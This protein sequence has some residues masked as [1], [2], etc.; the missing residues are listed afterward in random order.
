M[1]IHQINEP[2]HKK[3]HNLINFFFGLGL[4]EG[5][6][7]AGYLILLP[8]DSTSSQF[9]NLSPARLA[10][11][12]A[13]LFLLIIN[14]GAGY[15]Y[16]KNDNFR[17]KLGS[18]LTGE[19][20]GAI[21]LIS[22]AI[23]SLSIAAINI[24]LEVFRSTEVYLYYAY[25]QRLSPLLLY[26]AVWALQLG[27]I[28]CYINR[29][30]LIDCFKAESAFIKSW[31]FVFCGLILIVVLISVTRIGLNADIIG[32]GKP[33]VPLLEW[34]IWLGILLVLLARIFANGRL[35]SSFTKFQAS[36]KVLSNFLLS[37]FIWGGAVI[38]WAGQP[39]PPGFF[40]TAPRPPNFEIYPFSD[41]AFYD[42]HAQSM[43]IGMGFRGDSIPPRPLY[44]L[45]LT[46]YHLI[47]GQDYSKVILVQTFILALFPMIVFWIGKK[48]ANQT[49]GF[50]TSLF[51]I[52]REWT[53]ILATPFTSDISNSKLLFADLPAALAISLLLLIVI[54]WLEKP[55][56]RLYALQAGGILGICLLI[57]T[58][59]IILLPIIL[60]FYW[61]SARKLKFK[62]LFL[63]TILFMIGFIL[64]I[65]PWLFRNYQ[66]TGQLVFDHPESQTRVMAQRYST[67]SDLSDLEARPDETTGQYNQRLTDY[68]RQQILKNPGLPVQ[69]STAH[70]LNSEISNLLTFPIRFSI[71]SPQEI[72]LPN[73]AF[74]EEWQG[75]LKPDQFILFMGNLAI[76]AAGAVFLVKKKSWIGL[77]PLAF[78]AAYHFSNA[79]ARNSGW[80]YLLPADWIILLYFIGGIFALVNLGKNKPSEETCKPLLME[81]SEKPRWG[82]LGLVSAGILF[83]GSLPL[84][85]ETSFLKIY[86]PA[87]VVTAHQV[88]AS[89]LNNLPTAVQTGIEKLLQDPNVIVLNGR[90]LYPRY[91]G[92]KEGEE[93]T[94]KTGYTPLPFSRYVFL[95]AGEPEG[96]IIFPYT[97][98]ELP[99]RNAET[100]LV[101]G[102][103][104]GLAVKARLVFVFAAQAQPYIADAPVDWT[105]P[106][107]K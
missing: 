70:F 20:S 45:L 94:G 96:T 32:W 27:L 57:R 5:I 97:S 82:W 90:M 83:T 47:A 63:P 21:I 98:P 38:L 16:F 64:A 17:L 77:L 65:S 3:I 69:F 67:D 18:F 85:A 60:V 48:L 22:I 41:A 33:T 84:I 81:S 10:I 71:N 2:Q 53:S 43:L 91:Y 37:I 66:I 12:I 101:V 68:I 80:R 62:S 76:V 30:R 79:A 13:I 87:T 9:F 6:F 40:A 61:I 39:V 49:V 52:L 99:L 89:E 23:A 75:F 106:V 24:L 29:K 34:Q 19:K 104:D 44:I 88:L 55:K 1:G 11:L 50:V 86:S 7:S 56:R 26:V 58:Q 59:I 72:L 46:V 54:F 107:T 105:C 8:S 28:T 51:I 14:S 102:C 93:R 100:A 92:E 4:L 103:K 78:N 95:V 36:H 74:W 25:A 31:L 73:H 35:F 42:F 15:L